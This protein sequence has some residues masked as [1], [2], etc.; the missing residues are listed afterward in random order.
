MTKSLECDSDASR[1]TQLAV[2]SWQATN[3][4]RWTKDEEFQHFNHNDAVGADW[5]TVRGARNIHFR[6][7]G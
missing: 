3:G 7:E 4:W 5:V 6:G 1:V 2:T